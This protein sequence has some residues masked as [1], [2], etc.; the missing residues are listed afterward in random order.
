MLASL[1]RHELDS[2]ID[3][4]SHTTGRT[5]LHV[6]VREVRRLDETRYGRSDFVCRPLLRTVDFAI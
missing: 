6:V 2:L 1:A 3:P 4:F 5:V